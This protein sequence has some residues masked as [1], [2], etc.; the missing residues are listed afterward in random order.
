MTGDEIRT[1]FRQFVGD[2]QFRAFTF[3]M[4][5]SLGTTHFASHHRDLWEAFCNEC[6]DAPHE[7]EDI[8]TLLLYCHVHELPLESD[9]LRHPSVDRKTLRRI[10]HEK[11]S[12]E[13]YDAAATAFPHGH[14]GLN[15]SC[16]ECVAAH[17]RWLDAHPNWQK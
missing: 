13:W 17:I 4:V 16:L 6:A 8:R 14:G 15:V 7:L 3:T 10:K 1:Q 11:R 9:Q 5:N 2:E 12:S